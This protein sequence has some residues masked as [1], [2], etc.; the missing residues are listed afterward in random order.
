VDL[1]D[2]FEYYKAIGRVIE[3]LN[4]RDKDAL[5]AFWSGLTAS[6]IIMQREAGFIHNIPAAASR[7]GISAPLENLEVGSRALPVSS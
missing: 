7:E 3:I 6:E 4:W 1:N 2:R 5:R